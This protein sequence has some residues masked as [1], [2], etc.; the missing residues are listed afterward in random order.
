MTPMVK[1]CMDLADHRSHLERIN[2]NPPGYSMAW[3]P[4]A[5]RFH[6]RGSEPPLLKGDPRAF[7]EPI[8]AP[9]AGPKS[10]EKLPDKPRP[11][12]SKK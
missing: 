8:L 3:L 5:A 1:H 7:P 10:D 2:D 9:R 11:E 6:P 4:N 12:A